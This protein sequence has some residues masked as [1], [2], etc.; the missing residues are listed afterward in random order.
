MNESM[1]HHTDFLGDTAH[2]HTHIHPGM[3]NHIITF[4]YFIT[5]HSSDVVQSHWCSHS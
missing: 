3:Q 5:R 2:T 1:L 4:H